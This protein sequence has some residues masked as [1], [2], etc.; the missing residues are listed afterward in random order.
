MPAL[1][2]H[3]LRLPLPALP[4]RSI[5]RGHGSLK[6]RAM[7]LLLSHPGSVVIA[8]FFR[9]CV[10]SENMISSKEFF[11]G[12]FFVFVRVKSTSAFCSASSCPVSCGGTSIMYRYT[13]ALQRQQQQQQQT[14]YT[15]LVGVR[16]ALCPRF[17][18]SALPFSPHVYLFVY[19]STRTRSAQQSAA[20]V[21][22]FTTCLHR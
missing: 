16:T 14:T 18:P 2:C 20:R 13:A 5:R 3:C 17:F 11:G 4:Y 15:L 19:T 7:N 10:N 22:V 1:P 21:H 12:S 9:V 8:F 6:P